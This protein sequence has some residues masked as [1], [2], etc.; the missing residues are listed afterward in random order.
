[1]YAGDLGR[2]KALVAVLASAPK[3]A[4]L[5]RLSDRLPKS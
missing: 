4:P 1:L 3:L 2:V 5:V